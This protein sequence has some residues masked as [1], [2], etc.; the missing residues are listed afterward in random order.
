MT[1]F[2]CLR[3]ETPPAWRARSPYLHSPGTG[4][5]VIHPEALGSLF[6]ASY[7]SQGYGG[8]FRPVLHTGSPNN[9]FSL[10]E[11]KTPLPTV[12]LLSHLSVAAWTCL[13]W[14]CLETDIVLEPFDSNCYISGFTVLAFSKCDTVF[15]GSGGVVPCICNL[16]TRGWTASAHLILGNESQYHE[17][18]PIESYDG[19]LGI[20]VTQCTQGYHIGMFVRGSVR[21]RGARY[22]L[23]DVEVCNRWQGSDRRYYL[24]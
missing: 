12:P 8:G 5:P 21:L 16:S 1:I 24:S 20:A 3:F 7:Y 11:Q 2:H 19:S 17:N 18:N 4:C 13:P 9:H 23:E 10:T 14:R 22:V 15:C 6:V